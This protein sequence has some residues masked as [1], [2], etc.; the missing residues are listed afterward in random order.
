MIS[1]G[2]IQ[3]ATCACIS[4]PGKY[5]EPGKDFSR[6]DLGPHSCENYTACVLRRPPLALPPLAA[7]CAYPHA[8]RHQ[9]LQT[10]ALLAVASLIFTHCSGRW[11][12]GRGTVGPHQPCVAAYYGPYDR[13]VRGT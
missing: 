4:R 3:R 2:V 1:W 7:R 9:L 5:N 13:R 10:V 6:T 11:A 8:L 12:R